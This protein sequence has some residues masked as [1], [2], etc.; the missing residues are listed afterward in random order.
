[1]N[2]TEDTAKAVLTTVMRLKPTEEQLR[3][4]TEIHHMIDEVPK[5]GNAIDDVDYFARDQFLHKYTHR[6]Q[7]LNICQPP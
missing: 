3:R 1:M 2:V 6:I 5:Y 7:L 4:F